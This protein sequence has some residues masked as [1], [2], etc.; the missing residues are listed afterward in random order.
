MS[1]ILVI[2]PNSSHAVT[3]GMDQALDPLRMEG[4]PTIE[5]VTLAEGPPGIETQEHIDAVVEPLCSLVAQRSS[6]VGAFVIACYSDP[7]LQQARSRTSA[8]V[9]GIAESAML[10]ALSRGRRFGVIS[11]LETSIPRHHRYVRTLGLESRCAGDRAIGLGVAELTDEDVTLE[12]LVSVG[13]EL[14]DE[15]GADVV[16]LGCA[17]MARYRR[18]V[19]EAMGVPVV[20][21]TYAAVTLAL[22]AVMQ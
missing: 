6:D 10:T 4:G 17:G 22:G 18:R 14:R 1:R 20:E 19:E 7:G 2:N 8:P 15:D 11:I 3:E 5:C 12:R 16:I 9:F 13:R 21:P